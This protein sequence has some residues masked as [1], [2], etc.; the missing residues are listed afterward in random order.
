[1]VTLLILVGLNMRTGLTIVPPVLSNIQHSLNLPGWF[2]G[3]LTTIPLLCFTAVSPF[4]DRLRQKFGL[5]RILSIALLVLA[6]GFFIRVYS[7]ELLLLGT[8]LVG[9]GIAVLNVLAPAIVSTFFPNKIGVMTSVYSLSMT[10]FSAVSAGI[11]APVASQIG[12]Q[13][14]FQVLV[15]FPILT[16]LVALATKR[17]QAAAPKTAQA[18]TTE[19]PNANVWKQKTSW[20]MT[21]YMGI[22]SLLFYTIL[23]WLP[24]ILVDHG[25]SQNT[26]SLLL[27]V[28]QL[29][30][31]PMSYLIP[32]IAGH[33]QR[34]APLMLMT[35]LLFLIGLGSLL[36]PGTSIGLGIFSCIFLGFAT[37]SGFNM[38]MILFS[39][40]SRNLSETVAVSGMAQS[41]GYLIAA[42]G[43][44]AAS[45]LYS[46]WHSWGFI[47]GLLMVMALLMLSFG[48]LLDRHQYFFE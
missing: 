47:I 19:V 20:F 18:T 33:R 44:I 42:V 24:Q 38:S 23:T 39:L 10:I 1:M 16:G 22:Q 46:Q 3:S 28:M 40:K 30:A 43:P 7:F 21:G 6:A 34:Q 17:Y 4:V 8:L 31:V 37:N 2:L 35:G 13:T 5:I 14:M 29:A 12:W 15:F 25:L 45:M 11:S 9:A 27:G 26:S 41:M 32:I 48:L 36:I